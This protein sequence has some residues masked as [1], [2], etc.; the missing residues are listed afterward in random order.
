[1]KKGRQGIMKARHLFL[2]VVLFILGVGTF[3]PSASFAQRYPDHPIQLVI[4]NPPGASMD[5]AARMLAQELEQTLGAKIIPNNKPGA[6]T[7]L[8][9]EAVVRAKKDGYTLLYT[10]AGAMTFAPILNPEIVH[11]DPLKDLE[12]L[13]FH[14][15]FPSGINARTDS[16]WKT[17]SE[18]INYAKKNPEKLRVSTTG[19]GS[20]P[21]FML[22]MIQSMTGAQF[23]HVPFEQGEAVVT[24]V[25]GGHVELSCDA[26]SKMKPHIDSGKIRVLLT[27]YKIPAFPEIPTITELGYKQKLPNS[28]FAIYAP[29]GIPEEARKVL[30][31][32][33]EKAIKNT[34]KNIEDLWGICEYK[35]PSETRKMMEEDSKQMN[36]VAV[37]VGLRKK[38]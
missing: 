20:L 14:Y 36:E 11:Y 33:V 21:H 16:P 19:V 18:L 23:T 9:T 7:V 1:M 31:P 4:P 22:E 13:G 37:R 10:G 38:Q 3:A 2:F 5:I 8:G 26:F 34:K 25:L 35:S 15:L 12:P 6:A 28:W 27:N 29:T 17:F 24:A 30:V 32:A